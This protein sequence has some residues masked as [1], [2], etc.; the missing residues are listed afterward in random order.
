ARATASPCA[1]GA[2]KAEPPEKG[3]GVVS[4]PGPGRKRLPTPF[5]TRPG[6]PASLPSCTIAAVRRLVPSPRREPLMPPPLLP[7]LPHPPRRG[8]PIRP[9]PLA[10]LLAGAG[11][12]AL[13]GARAPADAPPDAAK[14][15]RL[16]EQLGSPSFAEREAASAALEAAGEPALPA[17]AKAAESDDA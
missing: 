2:R 15:R 6:C 3:S 10:P 16:V 12:L 11:F 4:G 13:A 5:P 1:A 17:L 7:T 14:I 8:A 9:P